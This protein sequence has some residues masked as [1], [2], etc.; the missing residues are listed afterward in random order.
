MYGDLES[1]SQRRVRWLARIAFFWAALLMLRLVQLQVFAHTELA[2]R[3]SRQQK[4]SVPVTPPRGAILGRDEAPLAFSRP[5][6]S[7]AVNARIMPNIP[8]HSQLI[9]SVLGEKP[10]VIQKL[11]EENKTK[12]FLVVRQGL[13]V[14]QSERLK[15]M[16]SDFLQVFPEFVREYPE[17]MMAAHV[18]GGLNFFND[19]SFGLEAWLNPDL[20][21]TEG[22]KLLFVDGKARP[23]GSVQTQAPLEGATIITS[24]D[25]VIQ[26]EA[27]R[28]LAEKMKSCRCDAGSVVVMNPHTGEI[29]ALAATPAVDRH[30]KLRDK[31]DL[32]QRRVRV[33]QDQFEPG[34]VM[35]TLTVSAGIDMGRITA[36]TMIPCPPS[37]KISGRKTP[38]TNGG[39]GSG[40]HT[41]RDVL[42]HSINTGTY[43][44]AANR[45]GYDNLH[46]Y[47]E[48]FGLG[49]QTGIELPGEAKGDIGTEKSFK[50]LATLGQVGRG[51]GMSASTIQLAQAYSIIA[52]GGRRVKPTLLRE[53]VSQGRAI[54][55]SDARNGQQ[56]LKPESAIAMRRLLEAVILSGTGGRA[57]LD[58]W[59]SAGKTGTSFITE[60]GKYTK[61]KN[62]SFVGFAPV[63]NPALVVAVSTHGGYDDAAVL[64]APV[65]REVMMKSLDLLGVQRDVPSRVVTEEER[66]RPA[67]TDAVEEEI[68]IV[69]DEAVAG[70]EPK[71]LEVGL[72]VPDFRGKPL[73]K[74]I[75]M[76]REA[77]MPFDPQ[78][79]GVARRQTPKA[80]S[81]L[82]PGER[83]RVEFA[84]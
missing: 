58:G 2:S 25:R 17:G 5:V 19:G 68:D 29:L 45:V 63:N 72:L 12:G 64:A 4:R 62:A 15:L 33:V 77:G 71:P 8:N 18:I 50:N 16:S 76:A 6:D 35:K 1:T 40:V 57:K 49:E 53:R 24:I 78:G 11:I 14:E 26:Y 69:E 56:V 66:A 59:S 3:A 7:L 55:I 47:F 30:K 10:A 74:V 42:A 31:A 52:N 54:K 43:Y 9:A 38:L 51:Y 60:N 44:I 28:I 22:R 34:S 48:A 27:E 81:R 23:V 13:T 70:S 75:R 65:F 73:D 79:S 80:G 39:H 37:V 82:K 83:I 21:G 32:N 61:K 84:R 46:R 36:D 67:E 20:Q 41:V